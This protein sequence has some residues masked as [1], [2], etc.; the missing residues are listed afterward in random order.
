[1]GSLVTKKDMLAISFVKGNGLCGAVSL[2]PLFLYIRADFRS[3]PGSGKRI[4]AVVERA[5]LTR[6]RVGRRSFNGAGA[7]GCLKLQG[8]L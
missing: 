6:Y 7:G 1:M 2:G 3:S 4:L 5:S 8:L